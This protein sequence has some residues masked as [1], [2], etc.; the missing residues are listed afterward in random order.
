DDT[1]DGWLKQVSNTKIT[2]Y[3][4]WERVRL[5]QADHKTIRQSDL[6]ASFSKDAAS[7]YELILALLDRTE[8]YGKLD[9]SADY[10][11]IAVH[12]LRTPLTLLRGYIEVFEDELGD[13]LT[14]ELQ[15]F[16]RKMSASA[17]SLTAF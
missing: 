13:N 17:Q 14:P 8:S 6:A 12:E 9:Q 11:A 4:T 1:L 2:D 16:M 3:K 7:G 5:T 15:G 10:V